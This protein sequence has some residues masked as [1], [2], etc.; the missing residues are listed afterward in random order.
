MTKDKTVWRLVGWSLTALFS[1]NTAISETK[2]RLET[3]TPTSHATHFHD[4]DSVATILQLCRQTKSSLSVPMFSGV[5]QLRQ[6]NSSLRIVLP[7]ISLT[8]IFVRFD[9]NSCIIFFGVPTSVDVHMRARNLRRTRT[10]H[11]LTLGELCYTLDLTQALNMKLIKF[12]D[13]G[14]IYGVY[15]FSRSTV[16]TTSRTARSRPHLATCRPYIRRRIR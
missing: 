10:I 6:T 12:C 15:I 4:D 2:D 7:V 9:S 13:R 11:N 8:H 3:Q 5:L 1:T 14:I 16:F